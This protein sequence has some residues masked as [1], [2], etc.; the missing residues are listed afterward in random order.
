VRILSALK[1]YTKNSYSKE[2]IVINLTKCERSERGVYITDRINPE[3][4]LDWGDAATYSYSFPS[5]SL[6]LAHGT[7]QMPTTCNDADDE[8]N[9]YIEREDD[10]DRLK[11]I[12]S[13]NLPKVNQ[14]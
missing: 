11:A 1:F 4:N 9:T 8:D 12:W 6:G 5:S 13:G 10:T 3:S 2:A 7:L 14:H